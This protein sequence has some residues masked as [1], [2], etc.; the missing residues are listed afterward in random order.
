MFVVNPTYSCPK[1]GHQV[2]SR[3]YCGII[4]NMYLQWVLFY[5]LVLLLHWS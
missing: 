1:L 3:S 2:T 4:M 5:L